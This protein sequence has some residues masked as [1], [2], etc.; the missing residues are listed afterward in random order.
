MK[1]KR[2]LRYFFIRLGNLIP[3]RHRKLSGID[4]YLIAIETL[5]E[6]ENTGTILIDHR[7]PGVVVA[8]E[9]FTLWNRAFT[10]YGDDRVL[11]AWCDKFRAAINLRR[12]KRYGANGDKFP[13]VLPSQPLLLTVVDPNDYSKPIYIG[14]ET[15]DD[16][17]FK[18]A[19][20]PPKEENEE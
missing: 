17:D 16:S 20:I 2:R 15:A 5:M 8:I 14:Y 6:L 18:T 10:H 4:K 7:R 11:H 12:G 3:F 9:Y 13:P 19:D 1:L